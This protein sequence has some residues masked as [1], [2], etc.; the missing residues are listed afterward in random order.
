MFA[1]LAFILTACGDSP[2][3]PDDA[4]SSAAA[5]VSTVVFEGVLEPKG[6]SF[7]S[8]TTVQTGVV[9]AMLGSLTLVGRR[10]ALVIPVSLGVGIPKGEGCAVSE[11]IETTPGLVAQ[12]SSSP[13]AP[14]IYCI[15][16]ADIG[17]LT[18]TANV[19]V[20]FSRSGA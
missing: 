15:N 12:L 2:A 10:E 18:G 7:Y 6:A 13:L 1:V 8:F 20:R 9:T 4:S 11:S 3:A 19:L 14:G 16:V 5:S 17:Y